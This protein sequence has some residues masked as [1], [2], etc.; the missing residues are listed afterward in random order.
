VSLDGLLL[1]GGAR[2]KPRSGTSALTRRLALR[3]Q[4]LN[5]AAQR[6]VLKLVELLL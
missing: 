2:S 6:A 5:P 4:Q 1:E 3:L